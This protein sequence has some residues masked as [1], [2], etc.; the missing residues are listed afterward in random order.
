MYHAMIIFWF[1]ICPDCFLVSGLPL[2]F[3]GFSFGGSVWQLVPR[4]ALLESKA[5]SAWVSTREAKH[6]ST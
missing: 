6:H 1:L 2:L 3:P 4:E 5:Y